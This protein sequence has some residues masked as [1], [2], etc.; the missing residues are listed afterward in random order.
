M[1]PRRARVS[2]KF[3]QIDLSS[4]NRDV[5][6]PSV[7]MIFAHSFSERSAMAVRP[8][9]RT[10][11]RGWGLPHFGNEVRA[12][13]V[14][15]PSGRSPKS[16]TLRL[17]WSKRTCASSP[18]HVRSAP[19]ANLSGCNG[20]SPARCGPSRTRQNAVTD[21]RRIA[22]FSRDIR[23]IWKQP[24]PGNY[25]MISP[26]TLEDFEAIELQ[27][28]ETSIFLRRFGSGPAV[29]LLHGFP[30][31]HLMWRYVA[32]LLAASR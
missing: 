5:E 30:Q 31:T 23:D 14:A 28:E 6:C 8:Y 25:A 19:F 22:S 18:R 10:R 27:A 7:G 4:F 3:W 32:P 29:L 20:L 9:L 15:G 13:S 17:P 11:R 2:Q 26:A 24:S 21:V 1:T 16:S 12:A